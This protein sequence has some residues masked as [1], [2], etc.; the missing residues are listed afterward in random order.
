MD[1]EIQ[2]IARNNDS[3]DIVTKETPF[4]PVSHIW[5]DHPADCGIL[6]IHQDELKVID[7]QVGAIEMSTGSLYVGQNIPVKRNTEGWCF[8]VVHRLEEST[9]SLQVGERVR[10]AVDQQRQHGFSLGHSAGHI[11]SLALNQVLTEKYWRKV[12]DRLDGLGSYDFN[13]YAQQKSVVST[14]KC[15][16]HYRLGK[17]LKKRG[18][19]TKDVMTDIKQIELQVNAL[20][21]HWL[22]HSTPVQMRLEGET[23]IDSRFWECTIG[24]TL[25]SMPCGG[26][27]INDLAQLHP[28]QIELQLIDDS[29]IEMHSYAIHKPQ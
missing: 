24:D 28:M 14:Q 20:L 19:N 2:L 25:V 11:A 7:C 27:H 10:L 16:D 4:H 26:T 13:S 9:V 22:S 18:L 6:R 15:W 17:T 21:E 8:V 29:N 1:S 23:L 12:P 5:P 3:L